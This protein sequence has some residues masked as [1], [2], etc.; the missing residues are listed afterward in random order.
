MKKEHPWPRNRAFEKAE[1]HQI[2]M[3]FPVRQ[4]N[5]LSA[6]KSQMPI[7]RLPTKNN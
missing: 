2:S 3:V 1:K 7:C 5:P 4:A 6:D